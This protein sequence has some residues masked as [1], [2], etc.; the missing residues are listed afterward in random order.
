MYWLSIWYPTFQRP[1]EIACGPW[2][3]S[4]VRS[5]FLRASIGQELLARDANPRNSTRVHAG[6]VLFVD[7]SLYVVRICCRALCRFAQSY[8]GLDPLRS[9]DHEEPSELDLDSLFSHHATRPTVKSSLHPERLSRSRATDLGILTGSLVHNVI[10]GLPAAKM[11]KWACTPGSGADH[12][13]ED[14]LARPIFGFRAMSSGNKAD[15]SSRRPSFAG[16]QEARERCDRRAVV[17]PRG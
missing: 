14:H 12:Q 17:V 16:S 10:R 2:R 13:H 4:V 8:L 15:E 7:Q 11:D 6:R 5:S 9:H 3:R 1:L